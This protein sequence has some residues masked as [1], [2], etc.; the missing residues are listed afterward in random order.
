MALGR[1]LNLL[2]LING[3]SQV[4]L[5]DV[6]VSADGKK[7]QIDGKNGLLGFTP[8]AKMLSI[9]IKSAVMVEG[10]EFDAIVA[11]NSNNTYELQIPYGT[12]TLTSQGEFMTATIGQGVNASTEFSFE[13]IGTLEEP[14]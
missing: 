9:S 2:V 6:Q 4:L 5:Q 8:G 7:I 14:R 12:K 3:V 1:G 13:F 10:P 11:V